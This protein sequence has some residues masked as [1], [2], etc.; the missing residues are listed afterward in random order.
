MTWAP[1]YVTLTQLKDSL[2]ITDTNDD[3]M[4]G[5]AITAAS[6]AVDHHCGRQFGNVTSPE[7]RFYSPNWSHRRSWWTVPIDDLMTTTGLVIS[8]DTNGD[9]TYATTLVLNTDVR[10]YPANAAADGLPWTSLVANWDAAVLQTPNAFFDRSIRVTAQWGWT[11][12]PTEVV[13][14]T[15][16]QASRF[17]KRRDAPFGIAGSPE[18][19]SEL[20]LLA[21]PDPDVMVMLDRVR[22]PWGI[23]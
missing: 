9:G 16:I 3:A 1:D 11:A 13:Q 17:F 2:R 5:Y 21:K 15:L 18:M 4:L 7:D 20:R 14:A 6:R 22:R 23:G 12:F 19:G 10:L 8:S